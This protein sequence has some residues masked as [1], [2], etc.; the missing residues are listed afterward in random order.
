MTAQLSGALLYVLFIIGVSA[1]LATLGWTWANDV[2]AL[3]KAPVVAVVTLPDDIFTTKEIK[4]EREGEDGTVT[5]ETETVKRADM[6][7]VAGLLR[8]EG[9]I[10]YKFLFKI[11]ASFTGADVELAAGTYELDSDM[12]YRA[13]LAN[14]GRNSAT[15][16]VVEVTIPEGYNVDQIFALLE[17]KGVA[18]VKELEEMAA[19]HDY[20]FEWLVPLNIP[21]GDYHRLEG[22][23]FP[24]TYQFYMGQDPLYV[25]NKMLQGFDAKI[26][27][28]LEEINANEDYNL[29]DLVTIA[30]MIEKETDGTDQSTIASV[31]YN[32]L[33]DNS[34]GT[35]GY[36]QIDATLAYINGGKI[37]TEAD[38]SIE[39]PYNTYLY[40]GLPEGPIANP[41]MTALYSAMNPE[42]TRYYYYVLNPESGRHEFS[43]TYDDH[44]KLV[45]RYAS[46]G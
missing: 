35:R 31:I 3:N 42:N 4:V 26:M 13:L 45:N 28:Y 11:F 38:K 7:F 33:E 37:P 25:I 19:T 16:Q 39:S 46:N 30:S 41:G 8:E 29:Y 24:D 10:E 43:R 23:L 15:K 14:M 6:D 32:R 5:L 2:L 9:L 21:L 22:F 20:K 12:D 1:I 27:P 40:P 18:S 34:G 36:L 17:E 44:Q